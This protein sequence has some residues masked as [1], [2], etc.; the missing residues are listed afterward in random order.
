MCVSLGLCGGRSVILPCDTLLVSKDLNVKKGEVKDRKVKRFVQNESI[1]F[2]GEHSVTMVWVILKDYTLTCGW[3]SNDSKTHHSSR[4]RA[5]V[6]ARTYT[7]A[8]THTHAQTHTNTHT[9]TST[10]PSI[11][12]DLA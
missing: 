4:V 12:I 7:H 1:H 3:S 10:F 6:H 5:H 9:Q 11:T 8:R 2:N